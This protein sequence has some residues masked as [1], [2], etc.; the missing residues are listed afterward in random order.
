MLQQR[1][2]EIST[3]TLLDCCFCPIWASKILTKS[4][5]FSLE[6]LCKEAE[7]IW[8]ALKEEDWLEAFSSHPQIG[9]NK[10]QK[11][12]SAMHKKWSEEEQKNT[13]N[14]DSQILTNLAKLNKEY[15]EKFGFI[16]IV[17]ATGKNTLEILALLKKRIGN[18][19]KQELKNAAIEQNKIT[20]I[21]LKKIIL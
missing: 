3:K 5:F 15:F 6:E 1:Q 19:Y 13:K 18:S 21:R 16:F 10:A 4:P 11:E 2:I 14:T 7:K 12:G 8:F 17:C 9:E 20:L